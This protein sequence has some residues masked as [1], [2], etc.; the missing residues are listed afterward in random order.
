MIN[1]T[2]RTSTTYQPKAFA[3]N[4]SVLNTNAGANQ[5]N[6]LVSTQKV[7]FTPYTTVTMNTSAGTV[8]LNVSGYSGDGYLGVYLVNVNNQGYYLGVSISSQQQ[9]F[10]INL[11][12]NLAS[13]INPPNASVTISEIIIE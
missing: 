4:G 6:T 1:G 10:T 9:D 3:V 7:D 2:Y 8:T 13:T 5:C 12:D 11:V